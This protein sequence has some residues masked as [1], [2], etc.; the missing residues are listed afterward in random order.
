VIPL[1]LKGGE[2]VDILY[3]N[4]PLLFRGEPAPPWRGVPL[5][6]TVRERWCSSNTVSFFVLL[7]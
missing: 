4:F 3:F 6:G 2:S 1:L 7:Q 5:T